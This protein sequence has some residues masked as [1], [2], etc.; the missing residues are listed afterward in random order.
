MFPEFRFKCPALLGVQRLV[1]TSHN[2]SLLDI[3]DRLECQLHALAAIEGLNS[4]D[5]VHVSQDA[6]SH[7]LEMAHGFCDGFP[8]VAADPQTWRAVQRG[9][10]NDDF[11]QAQEITA[12]VLQRIQE[13]QDLLL[14][15]NL[16][17]VLVLPPAAEVGRR[18]PIGDF[19]R[20]RHAQ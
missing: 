16:D 7:L 6:A 20:D 12:V 10:L 3:F 17:F 2:I 8:V 14:V 19:K 1:G 9:V 13:L 11:D 4:L 5:Q 15:G 18:Q